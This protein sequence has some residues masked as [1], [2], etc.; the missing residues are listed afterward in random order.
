MNRSAMGRTR[1]LYV[2][3]A[4][5]IGAGIGWLIGSSPAWTTVG[6]IMGLGTALMIQV[7]R[8][9]PFVA[10]TVSIGA[11][12]GAYIGGTIVGV[13]CEP[14]GCAAFE[15]TAATITGV[16]ALVGIGLVVALATRSFDEYRD[17]AEQGRQPP[18]TGCNTGD[19]PSSD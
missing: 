9:R 3:L 14:Q 1:M 4:A 12:I 6:T 7:Y 17:A 16:G 18:T 2:A 19:G 10:I 15:A 11:G 8:V 13:L 5:M